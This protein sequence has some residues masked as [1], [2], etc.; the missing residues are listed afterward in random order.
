MVIGIN[1]SYGFIGYHLWVY[2]NYKCDDVKVIRLSKKLEN[3]LKIESK[4]MLTD[5]LFKFSVESVNTEKYLIFFFINSLEILK[6]FSI[7][8]L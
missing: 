6:T 3:W 8:A 4:R 5:V 7:P 1:G 2:L